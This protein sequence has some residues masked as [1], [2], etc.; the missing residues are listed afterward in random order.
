MKPTLILAL[1]GALIAAACGGGSEQVAGIDGRGNPSPAVGVVSKGTITG[2]GSIIV[3]GVTYNTNAATFTVD[4]SP[5]L[6]SDLAVGDVVIVQGTV[7]SDGSA[8]TATSVT[9]DDAVEGPV[10]GIDLDLQTLTVLGQLVQIDADT[11]FDDSIDTRSLDGLNITDVVEVSGFFRA[12]GSIAATRI[13]LKA[14]GGEFEL[15]GTVTNAGATSFEINGFTVDFS[16]AVLDN[17]FPNGVP[18]NDQRIEAKGNSVVNNAL[19]ATEV[20]FKGESFGDDGDRAEVEGYITRFGSAIDFEVEGVR[21]TTNAQTSYTGGDETNLAENRKVE[22]EGN[23]NTSGILV[24]SSVEFRATSALRV[25]SLVEDKQGGQLTVLGIVIRVDSATRYEDKSAADLEIFGFSQ[26]TVG[27][28]L[29]IRGYEDQ[30]GFIATRIERGDYAGDVALRGIVS[31][32][33]APAFSILGATVFTGAGT[34][35]FDNDG[36]EMQAAEFFL[37]A[38]GRLVDATGALNGSAID[39]VEVAFEN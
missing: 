19:I 13:E 35:F 1:G 31:D 5:G 12:D 26:I 6:Q 8:P 25:E 27:N 10:S 14:P 4:G 39:A 24:A 18:E 29:E 17:D 15:T 33:V 30:A 36:T 38:A 20:D 23:I 28:Y 22:I 2:F 7:N 34:R 3:N 32:V 21:V 37:Q 9:F 16:N 11:S